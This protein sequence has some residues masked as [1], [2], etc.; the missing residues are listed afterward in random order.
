MGQV[1]VRI[2]EHRPRMPA[3]GVEKMVPKEWA[4]KYAKIGI[5]EIIKGKGKSEPEQGSDTTSEG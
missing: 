4:E 2:L 1:K 5:V 3:V